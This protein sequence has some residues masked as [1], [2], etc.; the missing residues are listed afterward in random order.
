MKRLI[1]TLSIIFLI[2]PLTSLGYEEC[3]GTMDS[4]EIPCLLL[5]TTTDDC[6]TTYVTIYRNGSTELDTKQMF[7]Y[8]P[9][10]CNATF[11]Y[12]TPLG[13]YTGNYSNGD[14]FSIIVEDGNMNFFMLLVYLVFTLI[15]IIFIVFM[16]LFKESTA[17]AV[18]YGWMSTAIS[19][20]LAAIVLSPEYEVIHGVVL[21]IDVDVYLAIFS[22]TLALYTAI[23]SVNIRKSFKS[24]SNS[25]VVF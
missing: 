15:A 7:Q 10:D 12:S 21:L 13:T 18:V 6:S 5:L 25:E 23:A 2:L 9:I 19:S 11:N 3:K 14:S 16:H 20:I 8:S 22:F 17:S 24:Q 1:M 4:D